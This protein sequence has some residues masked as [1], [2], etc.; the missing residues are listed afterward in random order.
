[1]LTCRGATRPLPKNGAWKNS[2]KTQQLGHAQRSGPEGKNGRSSVK[3]GVL[4]RLR[5]RTIQ[6]EVSYILQMNVRRRCKKN[7]PSVLSCISKSTK[8]DCDY[9]SKVGTVYSG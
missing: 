8:E 5:C 3:D 2:M 4:E 7:S 9:G 6:K 1:M